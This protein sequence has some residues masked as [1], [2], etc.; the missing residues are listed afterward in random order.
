M[1]R[2]VSAKGREAVNSDIAALMRKIQVLEL[3]L[4]AE[5]AKRH[6]ELRIGFER[7][8]IAFEEEIRRRHKELRTHILTYLRNARPLVVLTAPLIYSLFV[9]LVLLDLSV[10]IYQ[11]ICFRAFRIERAR[12][13][14]YFVFDRNYLAYLNV[15]EKFNCAYCSYASGAI[16][17]IREVAARTE[18]HWCPIKHA[19]RIIGAHDHYREFIEFGDAE[20]YRAWLA[21]FSRSD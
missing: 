15:L 1:V 8:R 16:A 14:D 12:R 5:M 20:A 11:A 7:G 19:R 9:P 3:E 18:Q 21:K 17:F 4:E 2:A 6:A 13:R 10:V